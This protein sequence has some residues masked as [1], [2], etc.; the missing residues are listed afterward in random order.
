MNLELFSNKRQKPGWHY[1][2]MVAIP[3]GILYS[4]TMA[5]G[6]TWAN[7]GSDGGDLISAAAT[8]GIAH[9]SGY[10]TYLALARKFQLI[11]LGSLA[12]RTN[13]LSVVF[14]IL[15]A[16]LIY[17]LTDKWLSKEVLYKKNG[18]IIAGLAFGISPLFWGQAVITEVYTVNAFFVAFALWLLPIDSQA[19]GKWKVPFSGIVMGIGLG[20]HLTILLVLPAILLLIGASPQ[21][22]PK[23]RTNPGFMHYQ[24]VNWISLS[25]YSIGLF[26][27]LSICLSMYLGVK[28]NSPV[29]WGNPKKWESYWW[30]V[31][32]QLYKSYPFGLPGQLIISRLQSWAALILNQYGLWGLIVCLLGLFYGRPKLKSLY[33][34]TIWIAV[35]Y[36]VF[37]I[38]YSSIDSQLYLIPVSIIFAIWF[39]WGVSELFLQL[40]KHK[41]HT[42][43]TTIFLAALLVYNAF[44]SFPKVD[45]SK[46]HRAEEFGREVMSSA[47]ENALIFTDNDQESFSLWYFHFA[48]RDRQ[49]LAIFVEGLLP[50]AW[51]RETL[52]A[53]YP[54]L[55]IPEYVITDWPTMLGVL[56]PNPICEVEVNAIDV[57]SCR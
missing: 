32:G 2:L 19:Q 43:I 30:L 44:R 54:K 5:P 28:S 12:F 39:G 22:D 37:A 42:W 45:A 48:L 52:R 17:E 25:R 31:S 47:P 14:A 20:N 29:R 13:M 18:G 33:I 24:D 23:N 7:H 46:D 55:N 51:Y 38:G 6:L 34:V 21:I 35:V 16:I 8:G 53:T 1:R 27:G 10:P 15:T 3:L 40:S 50:F 4:A 26:M 49:D 56:N 57:L 41:K 9:P 11:P 36:S